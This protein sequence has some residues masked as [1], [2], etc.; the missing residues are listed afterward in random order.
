MRIPQEPP[1]VG[2]FASAGEKN[3]RTGSN[4]KITGLLQEAILCTQIQQLMG[5][6]LGPEHLEHLSKHRTIQNGDTRDDKNLPTGRGVS[7]LNRCILSHTNSQSLQEVHMFS[8]SE[9]VYQ[10]K[11]LPLACSQLQWNSQWWPEWSK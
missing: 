1:L 8:R 3:C 7:D 5:T 2:G 10:F 11:A 6:Y 9:S 4:S